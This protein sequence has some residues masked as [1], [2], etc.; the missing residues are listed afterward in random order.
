[1][2][3]ARERAYL[4]IDR[5]VCQLNLRHIIKG[6]AKFTKAYKEVSPEKKVYLEVFIIENVNTDEED[7]KALKEAILEIAPDRVQLN[8]LD[9]PG[10]EQWV[11]PAPKEVME[12]VKAMLGLPNV[13]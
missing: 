12:S 3:A 4:R 6:I 11:V 5:P 1:L 8:T 13:E 7:V 9:R 10:A 2:D